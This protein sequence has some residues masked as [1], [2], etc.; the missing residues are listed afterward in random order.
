MRSHG[1]TCHPTQVNAPRLTPAMQAAWYS[2][3]LPRRDGRLSWLSW[4]DSAPAGSRTSDHSITSPTPKHC[5]IKTT[6]SPQTGKLPTCYAVW[7]CCGLVE[8]HGQQVRNK[9]ATSRCNGIWKTTRHNR[10]LPAP[11]CYGLVCMLRTS[12]LATGKSPTCFVGLLVTGNR[13]NGFW[14][15][16]RIVFFQV[17]EWNTPVVNE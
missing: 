11:T 3:Y 5:T 1:V 4:L 16:E 2:I 9:L 14:P 7:T 13:C 8:R 17:S 15:L 6:V 12:W 10:L